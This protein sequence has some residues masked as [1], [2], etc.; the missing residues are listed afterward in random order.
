V[1]VQLILKNSAVQDKEATAA[2]L[3]VGEIALNYYESG[4]FLQC[5]DTNGDVWRLGGVVIASTAPSSPSKG[6]WWLDSADN[7]LNFYN[8]TTW[9]DV[10]V[11]EIT[12]ADIAA[13]AEIAVS[14]L[15][16]GSARQ[17]L[18]TDAAGTGVEWASNIDVPGTL[19]VTGVATFDNNVIIEG[20]LTVNGTTTTIDTETILVKDKNIEMGVVATPTDTTADGGGITLKGA[21]DKTINWVNSTDAWT[22][23]ERFDFP[24]G[25]AAA[26]S[27]IL[28]G[29]VNSGIY[30]PGADQVAVATSGTGRLFVDA[31]GNVGVG[32]TSP[33]YPLVVASNI[34]ST[35]Q[36]L[37]GGS[38]NQSRLFFADANDIGIGRILYDHNDNSM[39]LYANNTE[40]LRIDSSGR[41]LVGTP[42][43]V[44]SD[45]VITPQ[46]QLAGANQSSSAVSVVNY[47]SGG[48]PSHLILGSSTGGSAAIQGLVNSGGTLGMIAFTGSDGT[49][50]V[51]AAFISA[52]VDGTPGASDMPGRLVFS[53]TADGANSPTKRVTIDSSGNVGIGETNPASKLHVYENSASPARIY[54][55]N[56]EGR[57]EIKA[58][59]NLALH[60]ST[61]FVFNNAAGT[62]EYARIDSSGRLLVGTSTVIANKSHLNGAINPQFEIDGTGIPNATLAIT[63]WNSASASPS[64]VVLSKSKSGTVGTRT[65]VANN[66]DIG[67]VVFTADDGTA[68]IPAANILAEV[69]GTPGANDMPGRLVFSTT[70]D[71][72]SSPTERLRI[73]S[74][75]RVGIGTGAPAEILALR[76]SSSAI[77][78]DT[79][80]S[81]TT[82]GN[83]E[84]L[85]GSPRSDTADGST[86]T[87]RGL[88]SCLGNSTSGTGTVWLQAA[89]AS[90][91]TGLTDTALKT[92]QCGIRLASDG[93][94]EHWGSG[95]QRLKI[96]TAGRLLV[97]TSSS[98]STA[99][100]GA[101][102]NVQIQSTGA[103]YANLSVI[104]NRNNTT[105]AYLT[106]ASSRSETA[107]GKTAVQSGDEISRITFEGADGTNYL[108][109][110]EIA[111]R[112]DGTPG[113]NDMPGR[114]EFSTTADGASS[115]TERVRIE[116]G[117]K[118]KFSGGAYGIERT[119][120]A[121][122]FDLNTGNFWTCGA[123]AIPNPT[124]QVAGMMG[125]LRVTA[126]PT[127]FA[128]NWKHP[129]GTYTAPTTFPAV[130]PFYVQASGTILLGSWTEGIA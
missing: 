77:Q 45:R 13:N 44:T 46:I 22:S 109:A 87:G 2:Q 62:Q 51:D 64:H 104:G 66:D 113:T 86:V 70:A 29:D 126:A 24:A 127:S 124:N 40:R 117:G 120:T 84:I 36:I 26:P 123:I 3:A 94:F 34:T 38:T 80:R 95:S 42:T 90:L 58:D 85:L 115:P 59:A 98:F 28:N 79:N 102:Q 97:G 5:K 112:V 61:Q 35:L 65:L 128:A 81:N 121:A 12:N 57:Y 129:G 39:Q 6:A 63:N 103:N 74:A 67:A 122:A 48:T 52:E 31:S 118:T 4:P 68:F 9:L 130:A 89:S 14:K 119:A 88:L 17:L 23:S 78:I 101:T 37:S 69:D 10:Q 11:G 93:S 76:S 108:R 72:A 107:G 73:D 53:T 33:A 41:L 25:T 47:N 71:G 106:L 83:A 56:T 7:S 43:S 75:G 100:A 114:L 8:G 30:Q 125:S 99:Y 1:A 116:S 18:Q 19:D 111:C 49:A 20:N 96:D 55:E 16:D 110:A 60:Y 105:G 50:P 54:L 32:T 92:K 91:T 27:I 82:Y 21:T 15:A